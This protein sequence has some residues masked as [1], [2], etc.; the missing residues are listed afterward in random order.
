M[1]ILYFAKIYCT[2]MYVEKQGQDSSTITSEIHSRNEAR[3]KR[4]ITQEFSA[5]PKE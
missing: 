3:F 2:Y 5:V 4:L 1:I